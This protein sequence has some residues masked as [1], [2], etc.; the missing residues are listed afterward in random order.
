MHRIFSVVLFWF[1]SSAVVGAVKSTTGVLELKVN[2]SSEATATLNDVGLGI[3]G[4]AQAKLHVHGNAIVSSLNVANVSSSANLA[5]PNMSFSQFSSSAGNVSISEHSYNI[6]DSSASNVNVTLP[7]A[8]EK[9]G[10]IYQVVKSKTLNEVRLLGGGN[11]I[12]QQGMLVMERD[13]LASVKVIANAGQWYVLDQKNTQNS[14]AADNLISWIDFNEGSGNNLKDRQTG[15]VGTK[16]G[17][18]SASDGWTAGVSGHGLQFDQSSK[19]LAFSDHENYTPFR[20]ATF[21]IWCKFDSLASSSGNQYVY[22]KRNSGSPYTSYILSQV[23]E[24][25]QDLVV[26]TWVQNTN[27]TWNRAKFSGHIEVG[28]WYHLVGRVH[29]SYL[30][31]IVNGVVGDVVDATFA[32]GGL[33]NSDSNL[34]LGVKNDVSED[35]FRGT[36]DDFKI[37]NRT[38]SDEEIQVLYQGGPY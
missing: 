3:G 30:E 15:L 11:A 34:V 33:F 8:V 17:F 19:S 37:F 1:C 16:I 9:D 28:R 29:S 12:D 38:L 21:S 13:K 24:E 14:V 25:G 26:F 31:V 4:V 27:N 10:C 7:S 6:I 35:P 23:Y 5:S 22:R 18:S 36:M 2:S 32:T 20:E